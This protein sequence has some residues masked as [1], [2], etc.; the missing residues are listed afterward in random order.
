M[1]RRAGRLAAGAAG[2]AVMLVAAPAAVAAPANIIG[3]VGSNDVFSAASYDHEAGTVATLTWA[4][5]GSHN[6]TA[7]ATG[8]DGKPLFSSDTIASGSTAVRGTQYLPPN[9]YP[10]SCTIHFGMNSTLNVNTGTPLPRPTVAVKLTSTKLAKVVAKKK[11]ATKVTLTGGEAARVAVK[12]GKRTLGSGTTSE[13][14]GLAVKLGGKGVKA[15]E[16]KKK[17]K[18]TLEASVDFGSPAKASGTLK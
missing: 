10:F 6:V 8:P 16:G 12:L 13:S 18:L 2:A 9:S 4:A 7:G 3:G 11:V 14:G 5:G 1:R 17:A 15:L